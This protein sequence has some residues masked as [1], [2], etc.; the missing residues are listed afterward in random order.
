MSGKA[1]M[2]KLTIAFRIA[3]PVVLVSLMVA[4]TA[5]LNC[6]ASAQN[7]TNQKQSAAE[8]SERTPDS[9]KNSAVDPPGAAAQPATTKSSTTSEQKLQLWRLGQLLAHCAFLGVGEE[10]SA[11]GVP[12]AYGV[13]KKIADSLNLTLSPLP[14]NSNGRGWALKDALEYTIK[15]MGPL[16]DAIEAKYGRTER[17]ITATAVKATVLRWVYV[18][19]KTNPAYEL[20]VSLCD[21]VKSSGSAVFPERIWKPITDAVSRNASKADLI[22]VI[23]SLPDA[24]ENYV[25]TNSGELQ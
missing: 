4:T 21:G 24:V 10:I 15:G 17:C 6:G 1:C 11:S 2:K 20:T 25:S 3:P 13:A 12:K 8:G 22:K 16:Y 23:D 19:D 14:V 18:Q 9:G 5:S 7:L